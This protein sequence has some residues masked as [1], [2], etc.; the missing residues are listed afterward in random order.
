MIPEIVLTTIVLVYLLLTYSNRK[1]L[2]KVLLY[3]A[4][5]HVP[6][7]VDLLTR[8]KRMPPAKV[9][10]EPVRFEDL[11]QAM[12]EEVAVPKP[13]ILRY[14]SID[15]IN[16]TRLIESTEKD[17]KFFASLFNWMILN[18]G[19]TI[20]MD[21]LGITNRAEIENYQRGIIGNPLV[22]YK[23]LEF[24]AKRYPKVLIEAA[25]TYLP[26]VFQKLIEAYIKNI[27][28]KEFVLCQRLKNLK[29]QSVAHI[30]MSREYG[31]V[32]RSVIT[33]SKF[34]EMLI[35]NPASVAELFIVAKYTT[36]M[37]TPFGTKL[38]IRR[39]T[40]K[41]NDSL[42]LIDAQPTVNQAILRQIFRDVVNYMNKLDLD[43]SDLLIEAM[44]KVLVI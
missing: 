33:P 8:S 21:T 10:G 23:M 14:F 1:A 5:K 2:K 11:I 41:G 13:R 38:F 30:D 15:A 12:G 40:I 20:T 25:K 37:D 16:I 34:M 35:S 32:L 3:K 4:K 28:P 18:F 9:E 44:K 36:G 29:I 17:K 22:K 39:A 6:D 19:E 43:P 7:L 31:P 27:I 42:I 24:F 26:P